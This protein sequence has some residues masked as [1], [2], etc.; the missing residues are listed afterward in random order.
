MKLLRIA[1]F[2]IA[3]VTAFLML[4]GSHP[5]EFMVADAIVVALL[6]I[7]GALPQARMSLPLM[8]AGFA[9]ALG[10]FVVAFGAA[11]FAGEPALPLLAG[12]LGCAAG[13]LLAGLMMAGALAGVDVSA[14][15]RS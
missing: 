12:I 1:A 14:T 3:G 15:R 5:P 13:S 8:L 9:F 2:V 11:A 6:V 7:G 10:V 4:A